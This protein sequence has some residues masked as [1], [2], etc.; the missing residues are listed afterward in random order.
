M[1]RMESITWCVE[2]IAYGYG[3]P[4]AVMEA[5]MNSLSHRENILN[6]YF[7]YHYIGIGCYIKDNGRIY[8]SQNFML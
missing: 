3:S 7:N 6:V 8:W 4:E 2:N 1:T 5:W